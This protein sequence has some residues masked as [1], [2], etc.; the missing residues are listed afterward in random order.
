MSIADQPVTRLL[1]EW[2]DGDGAALE[3]LLPIV[4]AEIHRLAA[5]YLRHER[6]G[7]TLSP[8]DLISEAF[9]RL[10]GAEQPDWSD[11]AHF[12]AIA[13]RHMRQILVDHARRRRAR[14]RGGG[15]ERV[16]LDETIALDRPLELVALDDALRA[17]A[18]VDERLAQLIELHYFGGLSQKE[19]AAVLKQHVNTVAKDLKLAEAWLARHAVA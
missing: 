14:K 10:A 7:H 19:I 13:A 16:T 12:F 6:G 4:Y 1:R 8:T 9:L 18:V 15:A 11:R 17:L 3:T 2:R 5:G